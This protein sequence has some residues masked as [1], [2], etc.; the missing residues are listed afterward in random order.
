MKRIFDPYFTTKEVGKGTGLG[1]AIVSGMVKRHQGAIEVQRSAGKGSTFSIYIPAIERKRQ[2]AIEG[3]YPLPGGGE[4]ILLIDD[5][6]SVLELGAAVL[7]ELG[8]RVAAHTDSAL[9][10]EAFTANP[11]EFDLVVTDYTMPK[12]TGPDVIDAIRKIRNDLPIILCT[13]G[14]EIAIDN[15]S[16]EHGPAV[17]PKPYTLRE[18]SDLVRR[19]I[20][21]EKDPSRD[22]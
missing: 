22:I 3:S 12:L 8:Y 20:D 4:K 17:L 13:G 11:R 1:L 6:Q 14:G 21:S 10:C 19:V 7:E 9:A 18:F 2:E 5:E 16:I 15:G